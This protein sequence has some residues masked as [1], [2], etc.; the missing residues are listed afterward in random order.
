MGWEIFGPP[1][2]TRPL[3]PT[4]AG[5]PKPEGGYGPWEAT[6]SPLVQRRRKPDGSYETRATPNAVPGGKPGL[7]KVAKPDT[8]AGAI[9]KEGFKLFGASAL[10]NVTS[11]PEQAEALFDAPRTLTRKAILGEPIATRETA[12]QLM[13]GPEQSAVGRDDPYRRLIRG[14]HQAQTERFAEASQ[15]LPAPVSAGLYG[16]VELGAGLVDPTNLPAAGPFKPPSAGREAVDLLGGITFRA[17]DDADLTTALRKGVEPVPFGGEDSFRFAAWLD[18]HGLD[19]DEA[20]R[21]GELPWLREKF[22]NLDNPDATPPASF[23][24]AKPGE[25]GHI[26]FGRDPDPD[27]DLGAMEAPD[28]PPPPAGPVRDPQMSTKA[29]ENVAGMQDEFADLVADNYDVVAKGRGPVRP[30]SVYHDANALA[31]ELG[32]TRE[33]FLEIAPRIGDKEVSLGKA[34]MAGAK[35]EINDLARQLA[36]GTAPDPIAAKARLDQLSVDVVRMMANIQGRF[37]EGGRVLRSGQEALGPFSLATTPK[38]KLQEGLLK[39]YRESLDDESID[40]ISKLGDPSSPGDMLGFLRKMER[41]AFKDYRMSYWINSVLSGTKTTLRNLNGNVV[42]LAE[43]TAM[44][45]AGAVVEAALAPLQGRA[46]ERLLR[47]TLPATMGVFRGVPEGL[48]RFAFVMK[49]GYD[50]ERLVAELTEGAGKKFDGRLPVDPFLLSQSPTVRG[51]GA[52]VTL[53]TRLLSATDAL[54]KTMASTSENY[55]WATRKAIQEGADDVP[56]RVAELIL[57]QPEEMVRAARAFAEKATFQDP[58]SWVGSAAAGLRRGVPGADKLADRLRAG[59]GVGRAVA[60]LVNAPRTVM[61][62]LLPF[63]HVSD[64]VAASVTDYIPGSK[65]FKLARQLAEKD[66]EA[67]DLI[68]RQAVGAGLG[69]LGLKWAAEG[70][71]VGSAPKDEA[72]RNDFYAEGKQPYSLLIGGKWVPIRDTLG[73][74]AGPFVAA[75]LYQDH[76]QANEDPVPATVGMTLSSARYMLDASYMS[77]LQDVIEAVETDNSGE[78]GKG[79]TQAAARVVGGYNFYSGLQRNVATTMDPRVVEREGFA[80]ELKSGVPGL[81]SELPARIGPRGEELVQATGALGGMSPVVPTENRVADPE[82]AERV[83]RLRYTL[84]GMRRQFGRTDRAIEAAER[85][86]AGEAG[87][88]GKDE[89]LRARAQQLRGQL[90]PMGDPTAAIDATLDDV[91]DLE[92]AIR[93]IRANPNLDEQAKREQEIYWQ[94]RL[95][96]LLQQSIDQLQGVQ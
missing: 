84:Q 21:F 96:L 46:P 40:L 24:G 11:A 49:N 36:G 72:L 38:E 37:S 90:P 1:A 17:L 31:D 91:R 65:P 23:Y 79:M 76:V 14:A 7:G 43:Q 5:P 73:P 12:E 87:L 6:A 27:V 64:R 83:E 51:V 78:V 8:S 45:P 15:D 4:L 55:A 74:L 47:E 85:G 77:T 75:A 18:K 95:E 39:R 9:A 28:L 92:Q 58:M 33:D 50:P 48:K 26:T 68:A 80:D 63:I 86:A 61:E 94:Q 16:A 20:E 57:E 62:H 41:P 69:M 44:R 32:M 2:P 35:Q 59:G 13:R 25:A 29:L 89:Q 67:S 60:P 71:L 54:F 3:L 34:F 19:Y 82:L 53:P 81:R 30:V 42:R 70:R 22:F 10:D 52:V 88:A 56:A 66:P 93:D